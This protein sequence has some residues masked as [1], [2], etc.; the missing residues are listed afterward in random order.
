E[1]YAELE[2]LLWTSSSLYSSDRFTCESRDSSELL[3]WSEDLGPDV[4]TLPTLRSANLVYNQDLEEGTLDELH[5]L[6]RLIFRNLQLG[7]KIPQV[8]LTLNRFGLI[9]QGDRFDILR[10][11]ETATR[12][13]ATTI[14]EAYPQLQYLGC[15]IE[16]SETFFERQLWFNRSK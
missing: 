12:E 2:D 10:G 4:S 8:L 9:I 3:C 11:S 15:R 1:L 16:T 6:V 14:K 5:D 7:R 13:L